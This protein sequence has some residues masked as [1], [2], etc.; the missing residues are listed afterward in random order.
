MLAAGFGPEVDVED[1]AALVV[2]LEGGGVLQVTATW[3]LRGRR[4]PAEVQ[5]S[6]GALFAEGPELTLVGADNNA[7]SL[8]VPPVERTI[9]DDFVEALRGNGPLPAPGRQVLESVK[10]LEACYRTIDPLR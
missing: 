2:G 1:T 4:P 6:E 5:G 7:R 8:P 9:T 3:T 10:V